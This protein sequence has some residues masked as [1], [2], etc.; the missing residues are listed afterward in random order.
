MESSKP[1]P[2]PSPLAA[3][4]PPHGVDLFTYATVSADLAEGD[5]AV[6]DVLRERGLTDAQWTEASLFWAARMGAD[7]RD[8][9]GRVAI[10]FSEAFAR[11]Q[12]LKRPL[13]ALGV[14]GWAALVHE[15]DVAGA[16][17]PALIARGL[18][19]ADHSR[20][21]RHWARAVATQRDVADRYTA[22][23]RAAE[24][25]RDAGAER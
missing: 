17:G 9:G 23:L 22:A 3:H 20:L 1:S 7:A 6:A 4:G 15:I 18:S 25:A 12:D 5:R 2:E 11:A 21:V 14:E 19:R 10:A 8:G 24:A 16:V 13:P